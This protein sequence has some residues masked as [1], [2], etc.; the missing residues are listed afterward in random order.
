MMV[1]SWRRKQGKDFEVMVSKN[2]GSV[3]CRC[4][5]SKSCWVDGKIPVIN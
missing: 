2:L 3:N 1:K 4:F 5:P